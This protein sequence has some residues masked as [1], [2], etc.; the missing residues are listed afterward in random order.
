M[1]EMVDMANKLGR[2]PDSD[3]QPAV[4]IISGRSCIR[5]ADT[6]HGFY[7]KDGGR[8]QFFNDKHSID[9]PPDR[10]YAFDMQVG[11]PGTIVAMRFSL[12]CHARMQ[13]PTP[14]D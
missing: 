7:E 11:F 4:T 6:F 2:T 9:L 14:D 8:L 1:M 3:R 5:F 13:E 12:D 10:H